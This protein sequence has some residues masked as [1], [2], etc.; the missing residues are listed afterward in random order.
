MAGGHGQG[1][2]LNQLNRPRSFTVDDHRTLYIAD[3]LNHRILAWRH[4]AKQGQVV[5][6][7]NGVGHQLNQLN[8]PMDVVIDRQANTI[9][10]CDRWNQRIMSWSLHSSNQNATTPQGKILVER[11]DCWGLAM[12]KK[13]SLYIGDPS[14]HVVKRFDNQDY[15]KGII[16]AGGHGTGSGLHQVDFPIS[17]FVDDDLNLYVSDLENRRVTKWNRGANEGIIVAGHNRRTTNEIN[18]SSPGGVWVDKCQRVYVVDAEHDQVMLWRRGIR[19]AEV[20]AGGHGRGSVESKFS[21]P[22]G[23]YIDKYGDLYIADQWNHRIQRFT[24]IE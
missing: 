19:E 6:G 24:P 21:R 2:Q 10:I 13:G 16:V 12:D 9:I 3:C 5:A 14:N 7:G 23:L 20:I 1:S 22:Q 15:K 8:H 17:L 18:L 11:M 4:D